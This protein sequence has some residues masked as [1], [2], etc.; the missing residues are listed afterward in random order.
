MMDRACKTSSAFFGVGSWFW[1]KVI[2][3]YTKL[4]GI[5]P[6]PTDI[7]GC[8]L[9]YQGISIVFAGYGIDNR[10]FHAHQVCRWIALT[11]GFG[12]LHDEHFIGAGA[13]NRTSYCDLVA[14][15]QETRRP[16]VRVVTLEPCN[17][18]FSFEPSAL[19]T[20]I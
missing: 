14:N 1:L 12:D 2:S 8:I 6:G 11:I 19:L 5:T 4:A 7:K 10:I 9:V 18:H 16:E 20:S 3:C 13:A 17:S 15:A